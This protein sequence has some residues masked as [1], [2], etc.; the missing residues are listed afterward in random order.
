M[1]I[2]TQDAHMWQ[3]SDVEASMDPP[4]RTACHCVLGIMICVSINFGFSLS[5]SVPPLISAWHLWFFSNL[6]AS[7]VQSP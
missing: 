5:L 4:N 7:D 6:F 1:S 2:H 3:N